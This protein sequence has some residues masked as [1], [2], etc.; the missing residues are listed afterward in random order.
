MVALKSKRMVMSKSA[1]ALLA[2]LASV[3]LPQVFHFIGAAT[4]QG[5]SLGASFLPMH[6]TVLFAGLYAG[7]W[8][9]L[10]AGLLSPATSFLLSG[11][12]ALA[13]LPFM[14]VE[15]GVYGLAAGLLRNARIPVVGKVLAAQ[16]AGRAVNLS[17]VAVVA[18]LGGAA[19]V[20]ATLGGLV[21]GLPG[22]LLQ[23]VLL[24]L[25]L[26]RVQKGRE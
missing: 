24:P 9:G 8:V 10:V 11:M 17:L 6:L 18:A 16:I 19:S 22:V 2:I 26:Y 5:N 21:T 23:L 13:I 14:T 25:L 15:L 3:A 12:P 7:P 20:Q 1:V 4:G